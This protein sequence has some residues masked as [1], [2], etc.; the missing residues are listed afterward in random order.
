MEGD[1]QLDAGLERYRHY[2]MTL[3]SAHVSPRLR[4]KLDLSGI[5]QETFLEAHRGWSRC[6]SPA[7]PAPVAWLRKILAHN[8]ADALRGLRSGKRDVARERSLEDL[9][10][11]SSAGLG[12]LLATHEP[13]PSS[14]ALRD[15]SAVRVAD[16]LAALPDAQRE[17][18]M[19]QYW[20]GWSLAEIGAHLGRSPAAV[21]GLLKRGI[22]QLRELLDTEERE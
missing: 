16:A 21:A 3:A 8:L 13:S 18:L 15:E 17:A 9:L 5:V 1:N 12:A 19:L 2:L 22:R 10:A 14:A 4:N 7:G 20:H 11:E 6:Q